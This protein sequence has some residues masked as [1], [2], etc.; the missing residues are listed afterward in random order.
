MRALG[1]FFLV[2][3]KKKKRQKQRKL[4]SRQGDGA[5]FSSAA[6][7][8][9]S[10]NT[11][12]QKDPAMSK[13]VL[14]DHR[15]SCKTTISDFPTI[16][17]TEEAYVDISAVVAAVSTEVGWYG[18]VDWTADNNLLI[19]KIYIPAQQCHAAT[20]EITATGMADL[21][22]SIMDEERE[23]GIDMD[24]SATNRLRYWGHSHVQ[25][26]V[27]ASGQ[28]D[29]QMKNFA[30]MGLEY[31][32]RGIHNKKG[33]TQFDIYYYRD[34]KIFMHFRDVEW[35][36]LPQENKY[37]EQIKK[38]EDLIKERV[39][40]FPTVVH[41]GYTPATTGPYR[42]RPDFDYEGYSPDSFHQ[43]G[44]VPQQ[45]SLLSGGTSDV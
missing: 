25:G 3:D 9:T 6:H 15:R 36:V 43:K 17:M 38:I 1:R 30:E 37:A 11:V 32:I 21:C 22:Q 29:L 39:S 12:L 23:A 35:E 45:G 31:M 2:R 26:A 18:V 20:T 14:M 33:D 41:S 24:H 8:Q 27:G 28:D 34:N 42:Y 10:L 13:I 4:L 16:Q 44:H 5:T 40:E 7:F 19:S